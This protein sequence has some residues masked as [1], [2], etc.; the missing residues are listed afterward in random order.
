M[1]RLPFSA[2]LFLSITSFAQPGHWRVGVQVGTATVDNTLT[3]SPSIPN[4]RLAILSPAGVAIRATVERSLTPSLSVRVGLGSTVARM[5]FRTTNEVRDSTGRLLISSS[6]GAGSSSGLTT[7]SAGLTFN[8]R[9]FGRV[10]FTGGL[11]GL[12]RINNRI[13]TG[14]RLSGGRMSSSYTLTGGRQINHETVFL[15]RSGPIVPVTLG[16]A[17]RAGLDYRLSQR[18]VFS[19]EAAYNHGFGLI[20]K[21]TATEL[22]L[23]GVAYE[24]EYSSRG[25][26]S[27]FRSI[28]EPTEVL[29]RVR[30]RRS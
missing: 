29:L 21:S 14:D 26:W 24:G 2:L 13:S 19:L 23:D 25:I 30:H 12:V 15:F 3:T 16:I 18:G 28:I 10:I 7:A 4:N 8:S 17:V 11:D 5:G 27:A 20:R 9:A 22:R 1:K 6:G